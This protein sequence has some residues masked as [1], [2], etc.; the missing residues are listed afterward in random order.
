VDFVKQWQGEADRIGESVGFFKFAAEH[1]PALVEK[2][3]RRMAGL[4]RR[5]SLDD[6]LREA[7][8]SGVV[9]F[10]EITGLPWTEIDF[11]HDLEYARNEVIP[12][13][14]GRASAR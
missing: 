10:E 8:K 9:G 5:D 1:I 6:V 14:A 7:V 11:P 12:A 13:L 3:R 2:T 4:S